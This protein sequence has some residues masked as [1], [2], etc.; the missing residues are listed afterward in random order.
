MKIHYQKFKKKK[1]ASLAQIP[2]HVMWPTEELLPQLLPRKIHLF[3][4]VFPRDS[5]HRY[6]ERNVSLRSNLGPNRFIKPPVQVGFLRFGVGDHSR[7]EPVIVEDEFDGRNCFQFVD[8][9]TEHAV[10]QGRRNELL[11]RPSPVELELPF[12]VKVPRCR[13]G[14]EEET[15]THLSTKSARL[16]DPAK[17]VLTEKTKLLKLI[18]PRI[19]SS[20]EEQKTE[21]HNRE[22]RLPDFHLNLLL[23][24]LEMCDRATITQ[25]LFRNK[26]IIYNNVCQAQKISISAVFTA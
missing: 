19:T 10:R 7:I 15:T 4:E 22:H 2:S 20:D 1:R 8:D 24:G 17:V 5:D 18:S 6:S 25:L 26:D 9:E 16:L 11:G 21:K 12:R 23:L 13:T 3:L 14:T